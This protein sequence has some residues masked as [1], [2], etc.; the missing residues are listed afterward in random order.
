MIRAA[1]LL[2][3]MNA[4]TAQRERM[5][6]EELA[7]VKADAV[8]C[9]ERMRA[10]FGRLPA[11]GIRQPGALTLQVAALLT[12]EWQETTVFSLALG[13]QTEMAADCMVT[14]LGR[15]ASEKLRDKVRGRPNKHRRGPHYDEMMAKWGVGV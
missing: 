15:G 4:D 7:R 8:K 14:L 2:E 11:R 9:N 13:L 12:D 1:A 6:A 3:A 5:F 10:M